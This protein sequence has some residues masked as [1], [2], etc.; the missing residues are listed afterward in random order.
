MEI[1]F[2]HYLPSLFA[3]L[4]LV[5]A[6]VHAQ[7]DQSGFISI[8]CGLPKRLSGYSEPDT[9][10]KYISDE[11]FVSA[12][13][14]ASLPPDFVTRYQKELEHVRAFPEGIRNCYTINVTSGTRYL[15]RA[16]FYYGNYDGKNYLPEFFIHI[17]ANVWDSITFFID[18]PLT[19][20]IIHV[21]SNE[22]LRVCL[23]SNGTGTPF[24]SALELRPLANNTYV[25]QSG[26]LELLTRMDLGSITNVTYRYPDD[27]KDRNW[28]YYDVNNFGANWTTLSTSLAVN[29]SLNYKL[30]PVVMS[31]AITPTK[32]DEPLIYEWST[33]S[34]K[35]AVYSFLHFAEVEKLKANEYRAFDI[36]MNGEHYF[37]PYAPKYLVMD[38]LYGDKALP[39]PSNIFGSYNFTLVKTAN[40]TLPPILNAIELYTSIDFSQ[41]ETNEEDVEAITM[42]K[43][44]Y[45]VKKNWGG[46]PCGPQKY[47]WTGVNCS[48][49]SDP[50]RIISLNLSSSWL[51]GEITSN[52]SKLTMLQTLDLFNNDLVGPVPEFLSQMPNL[53]VL[54]LA[55]NKFTGPIPA[56]LIAKSKSGSLSLSIDSTDSA[57]NTDDCTSSTCKRKNSSNIIIPVVASISGL[58]LL[59]SVAAAI[60]FFKWRR[61]QVASAKPQATSEPEIQFGLIESKK[62][63]FTYSE[64][65]NFT[66]NF[67]RIIGKGGFGTVYHGFIDN[68]EVA[69]KMLSS[70]S[71]QGYQ[72]FQAEVNLLMTVHH[73]NLTSL[74]GYCIE[75][76]KMALIYEYM[77]NG[78]LDLLLIDQKNENVLSWETRL[79]IAIDS[80]QGLEYL[81]SG[82]KPPIVHRDIKTT[83]IL[84]TNNFQAKLAD[85]GLSKSFPTDGGTYV[86][87]AIAGTPGYLDPE[88]SITNRLTEKSDV[89]SFGV[90]LLQIITSR[91]AILC[92]GNER[93][94]ISTWV[95]SMLGNGDVR[96]IIDPRLEQDF[97][98]NS[99]WKVVEIALACVSPKCSHRPNMSQ[100][101]A[102]LKE[103]LAAEFARKNHSRMTDSTNSTEVFSSTT[104]LTSAFGPLAR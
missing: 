35:K 45:G 72:Q 96:S 70:S 27:I 55:K 65:L 43:S 92:R 2:Y 104:S 77:S 68:T 47:V 7:D 1:I 53:R 76:T 60:L 101:V 83:N 12:G 62:R 37:G 16:T 13:V 67:E 14:S 49:G 86:S 69:I 30:S 22:H 24:I 31:T 8:D 56:G 79:Q 59:L 40:S 5:F 11:A 78:D 29:P 61:M 99:V 57:G 6:L 4:L 51:S 42:I 28:R 10:I 17:G 71:V 18:I 87:T 58:V 103:C 66:N 93:T 34:N 82:C 48:Y 38:T 89:Y 39:I 23:A 74:T 9:G 102:E 19:K 90:V 97:E 26:S 21:A 100:V 36:Y 41:L 15:I 94:H 32:P 25:T 33:Y 91:T 46:D 88:Y 84:L 64:V 98:T 52:I 54:N 95:S 44:T 63:Q 20:E 80:A 73:R 85:F 3:Y 75:G 50:P 81:H